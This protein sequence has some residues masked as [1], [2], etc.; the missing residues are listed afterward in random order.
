M[1]QAYKELCAWFGSTGPYNTITME[2]CLRFWD[3]L[4]QSANSR[5]VWAT[6]N[7]VIYEHLN[8]RLRRFPNRPA[9]PEKR[10]VL[11]LPPQA[12]HHSNLADYS[13]AQSLVR[14][15]QSYGYDVYVAQWISA[16]TEHKNLGIADMIQLTDEAVDEIR[17]RTGIFKIHLVGQCQG[18]WQAAIYTSLFP[19]K[20]ASLITAAAPID[21]E[22]A[23]SSIVDYAHLPEDFFSYLV[24][25]GNGLMD[26]KY[27]LNGFKSLQA[28]EH[29]VEKYRRLWQWIEAHNEENINRFLTF[30]KWYEYTQKLPGRFYLEIIRFIFKENSLTQPGHLKLDGRPVDLRHIG[31]P[32]IIL[33]GKKDHITPPAQA[34]A[35]KN[36]ISTPGEDVIEILTE[37]GHIGTLMGTEA[38]RED[39]TRVNEV[40]DLVV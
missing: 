18:G 7:Y 23:P 15:F 22:A 40:L 3:V 26:G 16:A 31:C 21:M 19:E 38:L 12:G 37:G 35:L 25:L 17:N 20:I 14:V 39:W 11:I 1:A 24:A 4:Y 9:L 13:P 30:E 10:P 29:Y 33:A 28:Q 27:I 36:Y 5:P 32:V 34:F 8:L 6:P 2:N